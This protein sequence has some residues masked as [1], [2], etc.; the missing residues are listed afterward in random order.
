MEWQQR[1]LPVVVRTHHYAEKPRIKN[2]VVFRHNSHLLTK[3]KVSAILLRLITKNIT[4]H[5]TSMTL[6]FNYK[7]QVLR[8]IISSREFRFLAKNFY[9][10]SL[11]SFFEYL[12]Q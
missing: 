10:R 7:F 11:T 4:Y 8:I 12:N 1:Q 6:A 3:K 9:Q 2:L 5:R